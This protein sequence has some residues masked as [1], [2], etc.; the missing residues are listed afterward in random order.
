MLILKT[1][2]IFLYTIIIL[3]IWFLEKLFI[4]QQSSMLEANNSIINSQKYDLIHKQYILF[5]QF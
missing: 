2:G 4:G 5:K 1:F 3:S